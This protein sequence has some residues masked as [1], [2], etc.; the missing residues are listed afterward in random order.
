[1]TTKSDAAAYTEV[2]AYM[3]N[4]C[5]RL[6]MQKKTEKSNFLAILWL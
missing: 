1:M 5:T 3:H 6:A 4:G 2:Y